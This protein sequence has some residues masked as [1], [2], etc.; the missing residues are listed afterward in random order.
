MGVLISIGIGDHGRFIG[1]F[2]YSTS[3]QFT[4]GVLIFTQAF[5]GRRG[6]YVFI[7]STR[8]GVYTDFTRFAP[9]AI[10]ADQ[11]WFFP[12]VVRGFL[13]RGGSLGLSGVLGFRRWDDGVGAGPCNR[14]WLGNNA[15]GRDGN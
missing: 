5:A 12:N 3:G 11:F 1:R 15:R 2:T 7:T 6:L 13:S 14:F 10:F 8:G 9:I 4:L